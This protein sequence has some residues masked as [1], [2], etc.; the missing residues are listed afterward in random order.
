MQ[1]EEKRP[2]AKILVM[3]K[4]PLEQPK[5]PWTISGEGSL[6][7]RNVQKPKQT[8]CG[9]INVGCTNSFIFINKNGNTETLLEYYGKTEMSV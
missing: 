1:G 5:E 3:C 9:Q 6:Y 7:V 4:R 8:V 2:H